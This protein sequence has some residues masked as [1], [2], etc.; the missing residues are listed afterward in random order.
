MLSQIAIL[1]L[2]DRGFFYG[3]AQK[4]P[5]TCIGVKHRGGVLKLHS[6]DE[7]GARMPNSLVS[8]A[9]SRSRGAMFTRTAMIALSLSPETCSRKM[10][11]YHD[12][13]VS[14]PALNGCT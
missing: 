11:H 2:S 1:L 10:S 12:F 14:M 5:L 8:I 3:S 7:F 13:R 6:N 4:P 9:S